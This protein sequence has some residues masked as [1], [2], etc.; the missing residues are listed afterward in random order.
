LLL[1]KPLIDCATPS[2][3]QIS[4]M[5]HQS[6]HLGGC[7]TRAMDDIGRNKNPETYAC[8]SQFLLF[9][10]RRHLNPAFS[11]SFSM[12]QKTI[13]LYLRME[14]MELDAIHEYLVQTLGKETV[15]YSLVTKYV[16]NA[17]FCTE[18]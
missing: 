10:R 7:K 14:R 6:R 4:V 3:V 13:I 11:F 2:V 16:R 8:S 18:D 17:R 15:A 5:N 12:D 9:L 1:E